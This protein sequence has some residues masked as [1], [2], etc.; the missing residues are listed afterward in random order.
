MVRKI[1]AITLCQATAKLSAGL[2]N[3]IQSCSDIK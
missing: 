1:A 3:F 2:V